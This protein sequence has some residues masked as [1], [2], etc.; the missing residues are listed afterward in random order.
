[1]YM[2]FFHRGQNAPGS[3]RYHVALL[4][5]P[6]NPAPTSERKFPDCY[7][8]HVT[9]AIDVRGCSNWRFVPS[10]TNSRTF[11]LTAVIL[12]GKIPTCISELTIRQ[13]IRQAPIIQDDLNWR[14]RHWVWDVVHVC[15]VFLT[16]FE[17][18]IELMT[19]INNQR[20]VDNGFLPP[21]PATVEE[22]Y[23]MGM[24]FA[25]RYPLDLES[26]VPTCDIYGIEIKSEIGAFQ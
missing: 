11:R 8:Y 13:L 10:V 25:D 9:N 2:A 17:A 24:A 4:L 15:I 1:M 5:T 21:L 22:I 26:P 12:L 23:N 6:K 7:L 14:Y 18:F 20:L 16:N 19:Q 3:A